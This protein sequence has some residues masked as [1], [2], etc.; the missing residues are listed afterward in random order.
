MKES[1]AVIVNCQQTIFKQKYIR[2]LV[3]QPDGISHAQS[4]AVD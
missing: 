4:G 2:N 3:V 1:D